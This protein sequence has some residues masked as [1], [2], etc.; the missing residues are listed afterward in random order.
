MAVDNIDLY[1]NEHAI[2]VV[3]FAVVFRSPLDSSDEARLE[4]HRSQLSELF[5][6]IDKPDF[7]QF[8]IGD[9]PPENHEKPVMYQFNDFSRDGKPE[10]AAQFGDNAVVVSCKKYSNWQVVWPKALERLTK[11]LACVDQFKPIASIEYSVTD[12]FSE[13]M[14]Q[15]DTP[16]QL[17]CSNIFKTGSWVPQNLSDYSDPRWDFQ[18]GTFSQGLT[19]FEVLERI[20]AR[21]VLSGQRIVTSVTNSLSHKFK[22]VPR[23]KA[24]LQSE[25]GENTIEKVF[26]AFHGTNKETI[27]SILK[28]E[29]TSKMGLL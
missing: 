14:H 26:V 28:K 16:Q 3:N 2:E 11:L 15:D 24:I 27:K 17:L 21:S 25:N 1:S 8:V 23:L 7:L 18:A 19:G 20:E 13:A 10:W 29:L 9:R 6:A 22:D 12:S 4:E 5:A